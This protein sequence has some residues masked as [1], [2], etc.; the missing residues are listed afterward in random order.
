[1]TQR[2]RLK[3]SSAYLAMETLRAGGSIE[4]RF[5]SAA[6]LP[7]AFFD[8][9][10]LIYADD[11][12][13][14]E[15]Q[16]VARALIEEYFSTGNGFVSIQVLQEYF[17]T[18]TKKLKMDLSIGRLKVELMS[19]FAA[20]ITLPEDVLSAIDIHRL[21]GLSFW[22]SMIVRSAKQTECRILF[23]EDMQ[24]GRVIDG[25]QITNPFLR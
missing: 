12:G 2:A 14:P 6:R 16:R 25:L 7:R 24:H 9:N 10:I 15:K 8:S 22:D 19:K 17:N 20:N 18:V 4:M 3:S 13:E 11:Q 1:M 21:H 23:S 5:M